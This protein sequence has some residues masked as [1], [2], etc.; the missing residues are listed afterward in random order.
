MCP[1][2]APSAPPAQLPVPNGKLPIP[3]CDQD[4]VTDN[5]SRHMTI[6]PAPLAGIRNPLKGWEAPVLS[7]HPCDGDV[8]GTGVLCIPNAG[9]PI[10]VNSDTATAPYMAFGDPH[11][12]I[13]SS[14]WVHAVLHPNRLELDCLLGDV[15]NPLFIPVRG[16]I[17]IT[18]AHT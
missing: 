11:S 2:H 17:T 4:H 15:W 6:N 1:G 18:K 10:R 13:G 12:Q 7:I 9:R 8:C 16:N 5:H 14:G 3:T